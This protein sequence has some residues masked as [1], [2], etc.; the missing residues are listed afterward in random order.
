MDYKTR[1]SKDITPWPNSKNNFRGWSQDKKSLYIQSNK[2]D[3]KFFDI[4]KLDTLTWTPVMIYQNDN[5]Y[6]PAGI[7][8]NEQYIALQQEITTD[9]SELYLYD[10]KAKT[11]KRISNDNEAIWAVAAFERDNS[12]MYYCSNDGNEFSSLYKY[13]IASGKSQ[14]IFSDKWDVMNMGL[15]ETGKYHTVFINEDGK[16]K[17]LLFDHATGK[18]VKLPDF[19]NGSVQ[20]VVISD[21][22][23]K[24]LLSVE[25][26]TSPSNLYV[27]DLITKKLT[28]LTSSL[29]KKIDENDLA[30]A[31]VIRFKSFDGKE[32][33]AIY[34]KPLQASKNNKVPAIIWVHG[35]PGGQSRMYYSNSLQ[36]L[37]NQGY[38]VL[39]VNNRGSAGY[40]K[41]FY[42]LD[43][44]DHG[45]GDV[46][47]CVWGKK[48]L[49]AQDYIDADAIGIVGGSYGG[50]V[51]LSALAFHPE[52]FKVGV[53]YYGVANWMRT[54]KSI[55]P[56]WEA[57]R[58]AFYDEIGNPYSKDSIRLKNISPINNY[59]KINKPLIVFQGANDVRVLPI[60]SEEIVKGVKKNGIPV[61]YVVFS[62]EGHG[63]A[64]KENQITAN[65]KTLA[66]LNKYLK[67]KKE[68]KK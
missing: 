67:P 59:Q 15:S 57:S 50:C 48:W 29:S 12:A 60:E 47:D 41:T 35:G 44:K 20:N 5:G 38:A 46:K 25:S 37:V 10:T 39:A 43:N 3:V 23:T 27:Y 19:D 7:S 65:K 45:N 24:L 1:K 42:K 51:V 8:R 18:E 30:K 21:S 40:G 58:K 28:Q 32:I 68:A 61:E 34:Y 17:V 14:K 11:T 2:R 33:P 26:T 16:D 36:Y 64:K 63:F 13:D 54:L 4:W 9:K 55:P 52:E 49:A 31:E 22:E 66:F 56:Y 62:D 6:S 53:D